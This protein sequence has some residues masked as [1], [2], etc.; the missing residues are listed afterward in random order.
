VADFELN[1]IYVCVFILGTL[2]GS[3]LNVCIYRI[4][5]KMSLLYPSSRCTSCGNPIKFYDNIPI[6]SYLILQ[7]KCRHCRAHYSARYL[8]I[9]AFNGVLYVLVV[10]RYG[11]EWS[12][13]FYCV[14][15][16]VMIVIFFIDLDLQ[17]IPDIITL[18]GILLGL[19]LG[20]FILPDPFARHVPLGI[21]TSFIG[22]V[23][24]F[25]FFYLTAIIG[26]AVFKK[27]AM[28]GGDIKMMAMIGAFL[29]WKGV[30]LT[31]FVASLFG[32]L[33]G[34]LMIVFSDKGEKVPFGPYLAFGSCVSVFSGQ[35][36]LNSYLRLSGF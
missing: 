36:I 15:V 22:A 4:P 26:R 32:A 29:G 30:I 27:D 34:T 31:T 20:G 19:I 23:A 10:M 28:G 16:S 8:F 5:R 3:F 13:L 14:F 6:V 21:K 9:E 24:G 2:I 35:E 18:P 11:V 7:G 1:V 17:I 33:L 25:S 12:A